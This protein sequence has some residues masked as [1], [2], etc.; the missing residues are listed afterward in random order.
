[1]KKYAPL[2][3]LVTVVLLGAALLVANMLSTPGAKAPAARP[4]S[5]APA[6]SAV[7]APAPATV[8]APANPAPVRASAGPAQA[9]PAPAAP[10]VAEKAYTGRSAGNEVTVAIAVKNG[11][12]VAYVC[13]GKKIESWMEGTMSGDR[14]NLQG[15]TGSLSA[16]AS[17]A[18]TLGSVTVDGAEWPFA[19]KG[20]KAPAGLYQGRGTIRGVAA[21]VGWIVDGDGK[22]T[23]VA[24]VA[25]ARQ[26]APP[27]D[28]AA[29]ASILVDG[30]ALTVTPVDG[31][32][33]V[34][35]R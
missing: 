24:N 20:V 22:V 18:E 33:S 28:P 9:A 23:G 29:P 13:D 30:G 4:V 3:T 25:G 15:K 11:K 19:A 17:E 26:P 16:T 8:P 14:L 34:M 12:A 31:G 27:I 7:A 32:T 35:P 2:V 5:A 10:V 6:P 21:R 1:M